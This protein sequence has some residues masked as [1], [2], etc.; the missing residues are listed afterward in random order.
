MDFNFGNAI[1]AVPDPYTRECLKKLGASVR[2][3]SATVSTII[4]EN[5]VIPPVITG[6]GV[7]GRVTKWTSA[8]ALGATG[9]TVNDGSYVATLDTT[10]LSAAG[11]FYLQTPTALGGYIVTGAGTPAPHATFAV[12]GGNGSEVVDS[13]LIDEAG[14]LTGQYSGLDINMS[15]GATFRLGDVV[16]GAGG[17]GYL[18]IAS[19]GGNVTFDAI[20][21]SPAFLFNDTA[22]FNQSS[23]AINLGQSGVVTSNVTD[24]AGKKTFKFRSQNALDPTKTDR[25]YF[26]FEDSSGNQLMS[27][28]ANGSWEI[29]GSG[30]TTG[31]LSIGSTRTTESVGLHMNPTLNTA[32]IAMSGTAGWNF[33][34]AGQFILNDHAS[35]TY[36]TIIGGV[37]GGGSVAARTHSR[38]FNKVS[39]FPTLPASTLTHGDIYAEYVVP[40]PTHIGATVRTINNTGFVYVPSLHT[41]VATPT[42]PSRPNVI[43]NYGLGYIEEQ[44]N[45]TTN[46]YGV[47]FASATNSYIAIGIGDATSSGAGIGGGSGSLNFYGST[48]NV[49][50]YD[51]EI[52][53]YDDDLVTY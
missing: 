33:A 39:R 27:M 14:V 35:A 10:L 42:Q 53:S 4:R 7:S 43:N 26:S 44:K 2:R 47:F 18:S 13:A 5:E 25:W 50:F 40:H 30:T 19:N 46:N 32:G 1:N 38:I 9:L 17:S 23:T 22:T 29:G 36:D 8:T 31:Y 24:G 12:F 20:G 16:G 48:F 28:R 6:G 37:F 21:G 51:N 3:T 34:A 45:A 11:T 41:S 15:S 49:V 52:V